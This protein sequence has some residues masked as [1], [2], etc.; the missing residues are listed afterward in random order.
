MQTANTHRWKR[1]VGMV[2]PLICSTFDR[3]WHTPFHFRLDL[4]SRSRCNSTRTNDRLIIWDRSHRNS[5][6][7]SFSPSVSFLHLLQ[8]SFHSSEIRAYNVP[9]SHGEHQSA[10]STE[11]IW[12]IVPCKR[13]YLIMEFHFLVTVLSPLISFAV[14]VKSAASRHF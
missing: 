14:A 13:V 7:S 2:Y 10:V 3:G 5:V 4:W 8:T 9:N 11:Y 1:D 6:V 12:I